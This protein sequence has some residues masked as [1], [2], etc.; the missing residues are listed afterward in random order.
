MDLISGDELMTK[1][2]LELKCVTSISHTALT[3]ST[4]RCGEKMGRN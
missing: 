3:Q 2:G 1:Q 4:R